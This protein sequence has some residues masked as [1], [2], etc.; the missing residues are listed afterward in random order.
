MLRLLICMKNTVDAKVYYEKTYKILKKYGFKSELGYSSE[1][2]KIQEMDEEKYKSYDVYLLDASDEDCLSLA[3]KIRY[4]DLTSSFI[5]MIPGDNK[6]ASS[7]I[8]YRPTFLIHVGNDSELIKSVRWCC[9]EQLHARSYFTVKNKDVQMRIKYDNISYFESHQRIVIMHTTQQKIEFY[10][11]L[12]DVQVLLPD[13]IFVRCHQS[14]IVN[15]GR[16]KMLDKTAKCFVMLSGDTIDISK[17]YYSAVLEEYE[18]YTEF[19]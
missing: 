14:Y 19:H 12:G 15:M 1:A 2:K 8:K 7:L 4:K 5:F 6:V 9:N 10:A 3:A 13:D 16:V 17:S 11:K 18:K